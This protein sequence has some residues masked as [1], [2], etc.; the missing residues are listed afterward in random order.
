MIQSICWVLVHSLWQGLLLALA[1]GGVILRTKRKAPAVRYRLLC[2]LAGIFLGVVGATLIYESILDTGSGGG[3]GKIGVSINW[4]GD[5][6]TA[7]ALQVVM[8]WLTVAIIKSVRMA[9]GWSYI[10]RLR[11][12]GLAAPAIWRE[13]VD[14]LSRQLGLHLAVKLVESALVRVPMV[15]GQLRPIIYIPLGLINHLPANEMEAVL[16]HELAH[17]R[18]YDHIVNMVQQ[19]AEC[20]LFFNPGFLWISSLIR[21]EREN[22]CDDMAIAYTQD[23]VGFVRALV[24]FKEHSMGGMALAF[25]GNRQQLL[26]R[27]LRI[28]RQENKTLGGKERLVL[29]GGCLMVLCLLV[30]RAD[31]KIKVA[32]VAET[33]LANAQVVSG[34]SKETFAVLQQREEVTQNMEWVKAQLDQLHHKP[35]VKK[36]TSEM[37][38]EAMNAERAE[39]FQRERE[40]RPEQAAEQA[41]Q[42][43]AEQDRQAAAEPDKQATAEQ[44]R[45]EAAEQIQEQKVAKEE[46]EVNRAQV[47]LEKLEADK[48]RKQAELD[49]Q[50]AE[51]DRHQADLDRLQAEQDRLQA[52]RDRK[53]AELDRKQADKERDQATREQQQQT[54]QDRK[55]AERDRQ[56]ARRDQQ[57]SKS[58]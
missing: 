45:Q 53:Q 11:R 35:A 41:S 29:L 12:E 37:D 54:E 27:V 15:I 25:P 58:N 48:D 39:Q 40:L 1:G 22:C 32:P 10:R 20:L 17:I 2:G 18:R 33:R 4:L 57:K 23:P 3:I 50:Q 13:R 14:L 55:Q 9:A 51:R 47:E 5:W 6:C 31:M 19:A 52:E 21:E 24:R 43:T 38:Q 42:A 8:V 34:V 44:A 46:E 7:H 36:K 16:L 56:Q 28:S 26:R 49:R 30:A